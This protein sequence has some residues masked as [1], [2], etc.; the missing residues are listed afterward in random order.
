MI[1]I[2]I[3]KSNLHEWKNKLPSHV[4]ALGFFDGLHKGHQQVILKAKYAA[5]QKNLSLSVM[6]FF[7]HPKS[8]LSKGQAKVDYLMPLEEKEKQLQEMGVDYFFI[9]EFSLGFAALSPQQFVMDYLIDLG[10][11]HAVCSFDYTYGQKG[12][13][14]VS[15]LAQHGNGRLEVTV[16]PKVDL[17][18]EKISSTRIRQLLAQGEIKY[19]TELLGKPYWVDWDAECGLSPFYTLPAPGLYEVTIQSDEQKYHGVVTVVNLE[20][21]NF[22]NVN[23]PSTGHFTITWHR[24]MKNEEYKAIS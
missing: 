13:G 1:T 23:I 5:K 16:V 6:S 17:Y 21:I 9:V 19:I 7:P 12:S 24:E 15:T 22:E 18:G 14:N 4:I 3:D 10:A 2:S 11:V 20:K 8:V